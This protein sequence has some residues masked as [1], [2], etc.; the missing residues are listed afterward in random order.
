MLDKIIQAKNAEEMVNHRYNEK[1][2]FKTHLQQILSE[3]WAMTKSFLTSGF[4]ECIYTLLIGGGIIGG[5]IYFLNEKDKKDYP[6]GNY[7]MVYKVYY[8]PT[9]TKTYTIKHNRPIECSSNKGTNYVKKY[10]GDIVI[11]TN[12]PIEVV[13]YVKYK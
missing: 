10:H 12:A 3:L 5:L 11:E 1:L 8:T 4:M 6:Y 2:P 9:N 7:E 13:R